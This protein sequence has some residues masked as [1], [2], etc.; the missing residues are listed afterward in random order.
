MCEITKNTHHATQHLNNDHK[1]SSS[2]DYKGKEN[3][4]L[5]YVCISEARFLTD[6]YSADA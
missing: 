4:Q 2:K 5:D 6:S 1:F 3:E